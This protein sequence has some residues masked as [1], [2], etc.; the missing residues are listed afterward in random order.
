MVAALHAPPE[1]SPYLFWDTDRTRLDWE[2]D[3]AFVIRRTF[4]RGSLNDLLEV[5]VH[6]GR[7]QV[8][9]VL[10]QVEDLP[11]GVAALASVLFNVPAH[12]FRCYTSTPSPQPS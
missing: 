5:L 3:A 9:G 8:V 12:E 2:R 10:T 7:E 6:Y 4:E 11:D 1:L